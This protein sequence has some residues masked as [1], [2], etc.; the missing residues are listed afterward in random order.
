[1]GSPAARR[2]SGTPSEAGK[3]PRTLVLL[4]VVA[5]MAVTLLGESLPKSLFWKLAAGVLGA[6][7]AA[8]LTMPARHHR[9]RVVAVALILVPFTVLRRSAEAE[10]SPRGGWLPASWTAVG[11]VAVLGFAGGSLATTALGNW[12]EA[13]EGTRA[14]V[15]IPAVAGEPE[16]RAVDILEQSGL[17]AKRRDDD[18]AKL[19]EGAVTRTSPRAGSEVDPGSTVL[20]YVSTGPRPT[21]TPTP[22]PTETPIGETVPVPEVARQTEEQARATLDDAGIGVS[23]TE[24]QESPIPQGSAVRTEP[25]VGSMVA[26]GADVVLYL[27]SGVAPPSPDPG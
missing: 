18:E 8:F 25:P 1:M 22:T 5:A 15:V 12:T 10:A 24:E 21:P 14:Q 19:D 7:V 17:V 20:L 11:A 4:A 2:R 13:E 26:E 23:R 16:S 9:R 3:S 27:S 6:L